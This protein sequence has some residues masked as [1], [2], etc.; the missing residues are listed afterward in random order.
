[1][2]LLILA[3]RVDRRLLELE[4]AGLPLVRHLITHAQSVADVETHF[5]PG[6][7]GL[8]AECND[9]TAKAESGADVLVL[10]EDLWLPQRAVDEVL[11]R[12]AQSQAAVAVGCRIRALTDRSAGQEV[13][14]VY[15]PAAVAAGV[16][17]QADSG[18]F[19]AGVSR[20]SEVLTASL[21]MDVYELEGAELPLRI[22]SLREIAV[23]E[24]EILDRRTQN[25]LRNGVRIHDPG[26]IAIR[27]ELHCGEGVE[28]DRNVIMEGRVVLGD[29]VMIGANSLLIDVTIGAQSV[30][31]PFSLVEGAVIGA[32]TV[33]GP[34]GRV[35]QGTTIGDEVQIGNFVEIK[36]S[37]IGGRSRINH[38]A[39][40]GDATLGTG[41]TL[42]AG[43]I[44]CNHD[45]VAVQHTQIDANAYVG[46]GSQ[47]IAPVHIGEDAVIGAGST[48]T[49]DAPAGRL[50]VAL[51]RQQTIEGWK[52]A[53]T[54][55]SD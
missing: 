35:R 49:K 54:K 20:L 15:L 40:V 22:R 25:A 6:T 37:E 45:G 14:A 30:V 55:L 9:I 42:G 17:R 18:G 19:E 29:G 7:K 50:T 52:R 39:F 12:T 1:M 24:K 28:I 8:A 36:K 47:L 34:Y 44:T 16:L 43:T 53:D 48:I 13:V 2:I 5:L 21:K 23:V 11:A 26:S 10:D 41:V 3:N 38:L 31:R 4:I 32:R 51:S 33:I 46:S 27:G